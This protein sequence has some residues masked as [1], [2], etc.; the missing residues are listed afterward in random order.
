M[1]LAQNTQVL[2]KSQ[3]D[4]IVDI[5]TLNVKFYVNTERFKGRSNMW[6]HSEGGHS[7]PQ[8]ALADVAGA[9]RAWAAQTRG[10]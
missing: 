2:I 8:G 1:W 6:L 7:V 9:F 5:E 10:R 3:C 4:D